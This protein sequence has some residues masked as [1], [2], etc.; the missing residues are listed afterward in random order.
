VL[1]CKAVLEHVGAT[2]LGTVLNQVKISDLGYSSYYYSYSYDPEHGHAMN[3][4]WWRKLLPG[5]KRKRRYQSAEIVESF[6]GANG[7]NGANGTVSSAEQTVTSGEYI[8]DK[9]EKPG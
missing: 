6:N 8:A 5:R 1:R 4:S 9:S 7:A 2:I 3:G